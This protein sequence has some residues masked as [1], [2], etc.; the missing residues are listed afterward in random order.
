MIVRVHRNLA[1]LSR[2]AAD[3]FCVRVGAAVRRRGRCD[4]VLAGGDTPRLT[5]AL[6]ATNPWR[7]RVDW[8]QVHVFWGDERCVAPD[9]PR[10]NARMARETLLDRV[11]IPADHIHPICCTGDPLRAAAAYE[12]ELRRHFGE[13]GPPGWDL[14]LLGLGEDGHTASLFP[15]GDAVWERERWVAAVLRPGSELHRISL[16]PAG[17]NGTAMAVFLV[18]GG[19]KAAALRA[20]RREPPDPGRCPAQIVAPRGGEPLL[21]V[22]REAAGELGGSA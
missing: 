6:L 8:G 22:D 3:L 2:A 19:R 16:T 18:A 17:L 7:D 15:G 14:V 4:V 12:E 11:P 5:Y 10:S 13:P 1:A 9:D 21:L 20:I